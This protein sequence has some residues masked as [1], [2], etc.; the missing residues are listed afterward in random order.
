MRWGRA[1][2]I[3]DLKLRIFS[4]TVALASLRPI[5]LS[6]SCNWRNS[7]VRQN[8]LATSGFQPHPDPV[9]RRWGRTGPRR[10]PGLP[11]GCSGSGSPP[12][13]RG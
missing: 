1:G 5:F 12:R 8:A 11:G 2:R 3:E 10:G 7:I 13:D 9:K 4:S 6:V